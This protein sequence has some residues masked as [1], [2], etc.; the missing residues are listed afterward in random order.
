MKENLSTLEKLP[1]RA[2]P[3]LPLCGTG[4]LKFGFMPFLLGVRPK[5][6]G[7]DLG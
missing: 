7:M 6:K 4:I 3:F 1:V 2:K 5:R